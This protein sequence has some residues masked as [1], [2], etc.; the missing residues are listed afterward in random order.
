MPPAPRPLPRRSGERATK[1]KLSLGPGDVMVMAG[2]TQQLWQHAV[3]RRAVVREPRVSLTF[4][5]LLQPA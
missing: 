2:A 5:R 3:P 1:L 4:R